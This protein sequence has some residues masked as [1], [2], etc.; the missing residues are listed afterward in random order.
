MKRHITLA[1]LFSLLVLP[2]LMAQDNVADKIL[3]TWLSGNKEGHIEIFKIGQMYYGKIVWSKNMLEA[4]G[5]T[6]KKDSKNEDESKRNR[7]I[8]NL[9]I[10]N[11]FIYK[12]GSYA[13]GTI[14]DPKNGKTYSCKMTLKGDQLDIRGFIG[15]SLLGRTDTW[16]RIK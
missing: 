4:D 13:G 2:S 15:I 11:S 10:L 8:K 12:N 9:V 6:L 16:E 5:K 7:H 14:Y 1:L 3:G